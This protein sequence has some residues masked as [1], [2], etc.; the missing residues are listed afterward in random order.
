MAGGAGEEPGAGH[1]VLDRLTGPRA[2]WKSAWLIDPSGIAMAG[3]S[4]GGSS[5]IP[6]LLSVRAGIDIDGTTDMAIPE[7]GLSLPFMVLGKP[8]TYSPGQG[9]AATWSEAAH[10]VE[11]PAPA[12]GAEHLSFTDL[13]V[14][15]DQLGIDA[16]AGIPGARAMAV[17]RA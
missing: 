17:T 13:G 9:D 7:G 6:A 3:R 14:L 4:V 15:V 10:R 1:V 11:A 5:T 8:S 16:G 12:V 2:A